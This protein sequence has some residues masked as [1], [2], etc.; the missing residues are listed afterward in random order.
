[1]SDAIKSLIS[2]LLASPD[3]ALRVEGSFLAALTAYGRFARASAQKEELLSALQTYLQ[4]FRQAWPTGNISDEADDAF[5]RMHTA[6]TAEIRMLIGD[7]ESVRRSGQIG[8]K[9]KLQ[10]AS[11]EPAKSAASFCIGVDQTSSC[12]SSLE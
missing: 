5:W 4:D 2:I 11:A 12:N 3:T 7:S 9:A 8:H 1:M 6:I 10:I